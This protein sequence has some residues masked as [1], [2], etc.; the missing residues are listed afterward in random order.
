V[1]DLLPIG[2]RSGPPRI[3]GDDA[4]TG[5]RLA[6][7]LARPWN[8]FDHRHGHA[9]SHTDAHQTIPG[10]LLQLAAYAP[11]LEER[12]GRRMGPELPGK[13]KVVEEEITETAERRAREV[14]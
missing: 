8:V 11:F 14:P 4:K 3:Q 9:F 5:R 1:A 6:T 10:Q 13:W 12:T 7:L 2:S